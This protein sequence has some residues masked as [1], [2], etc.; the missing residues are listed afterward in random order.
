[1]F[2]RFY[3]Q[4][5]FAG[6]ITVIWIIWFVRISSDGT[7]IKASFGYTAKKS[8]EQMPSDKLII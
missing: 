5:D 4:A 7:L 1:M 3:H 2:A 8:S 6:L